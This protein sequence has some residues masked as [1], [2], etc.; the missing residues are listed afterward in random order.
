MAMQSESVLDSPKEGLDPVVWSP[1][2]DGSYVLSPEARNKVRNVVA[3]ILRNTNFREFRANLTGSIASNQW[4]DDSDIDVHV[5]SPDVTDENKDEL[6]RELRRK[7]EEFA[8]NDPEAARIGNHPIE[9]YLQANPYQD[10]MS[11]GCYDIV[12]DKWLSGPQIVDPDYDPVSDYWDEDMDLVKDVVKDSWKIVRKAW[13]NAMA[14]KMSRDPEFREERF[15][16][17]VEQLEK[18]RKTYDD[19]RA[20]RTSQSS[21]RSEDEAERFRTSR[22]WKVAESAFKLLDKLG[23]L[24]TFKAF[25]KCLDSLEDGVSEEGIVETV[26]QVAKNVFETNLSEE[27]ESL[28]GMPG[29]MEDDLKDDL[30]GWIQERIDEYQL[31]IE[32]LDVAI[33]GSRM[34]GDHRNDSDLDCMVY[35]RGTR[36]DGKYAREDHIWNMLNDDPQCE[37]DGVA[38]D[39]W[40]IRDEESGSMDEVLPGVV[41]YG[42]ENPKKLDEEETVDEGLGKYLTVAGL[43]GLLSIPGVLGAE[44]LKKNLG[45]VSVSS[46]K[47]DSP[48][49]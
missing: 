11:V 42:R 18:A 40:P 10:L 33:F 3:W 12:D 13:E 34:R 26:L 49:V 19:L 39:F 32:L 21:P 15:E 22:E 8:A 6:N 35:Y 16:E 1:D 44:N 45:E 41:R 14:W 30:R 47:V 4:K 28:P 2:E 20:F 27:K 7:F 9:V 37:I 43:A 31:D 23:Y 38:V 46:L 24:R 48:N 36:P 29:W 17:V 5:G 25:S